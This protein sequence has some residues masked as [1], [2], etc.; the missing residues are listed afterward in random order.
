M[1]SFKEWENGVCSFP[2]QKAKMQ[3]RNAV[4]T[5][6]HRIIQWLV[7]LRVLTLPA[8]VQAQFT[9]PQSPPTISTQPNS[10]TNLVDS[11]VTFC[12]VVEGLGPFTYQWQFN[13]T[14][15][16][17]DIITTV[18]GNGSATYTGD[19]GAA[20]NASLNGLQ[21]VAF[22]IQGNLFI[23][24]TGNNCV[25]KVDTNGIITTVV[26][27]GSATY[28]GDGGNA[29]N[30]S[31]NVPSAVA[32]DISGNLLIA[33]QL[34]QRIRKVDAN[35]IITTV[36][37]NGNTLF[38]GSIS[39]TYSGDGGPATNAGLFWPSG[40]IVDTSGNMFIADNGNERIRKVDTNG[41]ITTVA[42]N[43]VQATG[44]DGGPATNALLDGPYAV[45]FDAA[46]NMHF[47]DTY[48][49][50]IR[51]VDASGIIS[52]VAGGNNL[53]YAT[54]DGGPAIN[55]TID[56]PFGLA[57]DTAGRLYIAAGY[58]NNDI[59]R[60]DTNGIITTV[61]G[62]GNGYHGG[63]A[64]PG[65]G[66]S[67]TNATLNS[68]YGLAF[69]ALGNLYIADAGNNRVREVHYSGYPT[70]TLTNLSAVN[71]GNYTVIIT[72]AYGS[73]TSIVAALTVVYPPSIISQPTS[74][75][76]SAGS[77]AN[78]NMTVTGTLPI[79]YS[80]YFNIISLIQT[81]TNASLL[82]SDFGP[83]NVGQ[84]TVIVT[85]A[86]GSVTSS[87]ATLEMPP[88]V[89]V[90]TPP[91]SQTLLSG[92]NVTFSVEVDGIGPFTYQWQFNGTN[93]PNNII[94][95]VAGGG[96]NYSGVGD[97]GLA[98]NASLYQ[99]CGLILDSTGNL[100]IADNG[101][102]RIRKVD[103]N[104]IITSVAGNGNEDFSG[105][106][107]AA[108]NT[109]LSSPK[110]VAIDSL[111]DLYIADSA[112]QRVRKVDT[113]GI[114]TTVVGNDNNGYFGSYSGDGG[115]ASN[116]TVNYPTGVSVDTLGN[117]YIADS[118]NNRIRRVDTHGVINTVA[119]NG[120]ASFTGDGGV[121]T[122]AGL[123]SPFS[124][125]A[126]VVGNLYIADSSNGR[127]RKES[128]NG[129]INTVA[130]GGSGGDGGAATN[131][132]LYNPHSVAM[133]ARGNLYI[134]DDEINP[135]RIRMVDTNGIIS[136]VAGGG[137]GGD[138]GPAT[139]ASLNA[140]Y[141]VAFDVV[142]NLYIADEGDN[143]VHEVHF[144]GYPKLTLTAR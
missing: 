69:D 122:N 99:P 80:W 89:S 60:V 35:G 94:T 38:P 92:S 1:L 71:A 19:G 109:S 142:G 118:G 50:S 72:N 8:V 30:A 9:Y 70:L 103:T 139:N 16:Q 110:G 112:N 11:N 74:Q 59:R 77:N 124:L 140:P 82:V 111:G 100:Y 85:N 31:L 136:T 24:D 20:T 121:A 56:W 119:G 3:T 5:R 23:A 84:Y 106:G 57:F 18:V 105:D 75:G 51:K 58:D 28:A 55:A 91:A 26:G 14:N 123:N 40:I 113:N 131:S 33:D 61:A 86:Y 54:G 98:T 65:D 25:R 90:I 135:D 81:G 73:V 48:H 42:G 29:I 95:T 47:S 13:N 128:P 64:N 39:G 78:L 104:G 125:F 43:G 137:A 134:T 116:A 132:T 87:L 107:V 63:G 36:A 52:T 12:V 41:I 62:A 2:M 76:I 22:D 143:L 102:N 117:L 83:A 10:Q 21:G 97:G 68:P 15:L 115:P 66:G 7:L 79:Y 96:F 130:G 67:A 53:N 114:I 101:H 4:E 129:I 34:N 88:A 27:N 17:N 44:V 108:T 37:G 144:A 32:F 45:A 93:L 141:G 120:T 46:G 49:N 6:N 127:I 133:D 126:D 138:G